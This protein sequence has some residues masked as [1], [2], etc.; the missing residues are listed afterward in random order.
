MI[1]IWA[2]ITGRKIVFLKDFEGEIYVS[3][4]RKTPFGYCAPIYWFTGTGCVT[5]EEDGTCGNSYISNWKFE[6]K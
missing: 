5:L 3:L 1:R 2:F 6:N 4:A